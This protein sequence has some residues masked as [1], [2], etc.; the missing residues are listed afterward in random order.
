MKQTPI[1][2]IRGKSETEGLTQSGTAKKAAKGTIV[3][4]A[5]TVI[6]TAFSVADN[7]LIIMLAAA[8]E[9]A[10]ARPPI[11]PR[12]NSINPGL[13]IISAPINPIKQAIHPPFPDKFF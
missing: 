12:F 13:T 10:A 8:K 4:F 1:R 3:T 7:F 2:K 5:A 11:A 9:S 6:R